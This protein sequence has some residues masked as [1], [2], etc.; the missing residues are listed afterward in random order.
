MSVEAGKWGVIYNPKAGTRKVQKRWKEIK[1][2]MDQKG[3][4]YD[5]VQSEGFGSVERL[6]GILA[7]NGYTTIVVVG[8]DGALNDAINGIML[9]NAEHKE[10]IAIGI[11]P[12]GIGNDF[13]RYWDIGMD[14]KQAV[15]WII[16][17]RH[18]KIDVGFCNF[19]D[20]EKHQRRY[21]LNAINIGFG[22]R[23]VKVTDGTKRF[24]GVKFLSYLAA[25]FLLFFER[26]LYRMHL[27]INDEHI[28]GRIM[29]V[30]V[31][32]A[33]GYGQTPSAVPYNGWLDVSVI[34][35]PQLLQTMSG[36][37]ML[38]Q[39]RI[40]NHKVVKSYRTKKV[41]VLRARNAAVD[42]DGRI[43]PKH[44]PLEIGILPEKITLIIP[45]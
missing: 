12:N 29:T 16:K 7:N 13:A 23:I 36:L 22:A 21:F 10:D 44:F 19:Y 35:R 3:V 45:D 37:W 25:F 6:A 14:Y 1:E 38:I 42:L 24:W 34:Y 20:G 27:R 30:C 5:Y 2:Y 18:R 32:S 31:G 33:C 39:G 9:S 17:N 26:N 11:I 41:K 28:R 4:A 8:G 15:D 40:L 43:L